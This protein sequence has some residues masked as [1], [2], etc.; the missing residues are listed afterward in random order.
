MLKEI[1]FEEALKLSRTSTLEDI[2]PD[3]TKIIKDVRH[4]GNAALRKYAEQYGDLSH[5]APLII[6]QSVLTAA[7][8]SI[9][10]EEQDLLYRTAERIR[11]FAEAQ[12]ST[13]TDLSFSIPGGTAGHTIR[14]LE[15]AACYVPG[16]RYPLPSSCLMTVCTA[17]TAGVKT[18][19]VASPRPNV[20]TMAA[21]A[22]AGADGL[23]AVG[24]AQAIAAMAY[25]T[26]QVP[27]FDI[28]VGPGNKWV[29]AAK[30]LVAGHVK[31]DMLAGPS[32]L[33]IVADASAD[34]EL[35]AADLL[36][37]AE[38]DPDSRVLLVTLDRRLIEEVHKEL[39]LQL[40]ILP[41]REVASQSISQGY[42]VVV[43]DLTQAGELSNTWGPEHLELQV[44]NSET[45]K[46][47]FTN[48]GSLFLGHNSAEVLGDY[49][50]GPNH[51]LPTSGS[52]KIRGGLS[53]FD[54]LKVQTWLNVKEVD[55]QLANDAIAL[56][57]LEGL[58]AHA[59]SLEKRLA[60]DTE[61]S[62]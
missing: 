25:G 1:S 18:V 11:T 42:V 60:K 34:P 41:T 44:A 5:D 14:P 54:F 49:G 46:K 26:E 56:A 58:S 59:R 36:A 32:E 52:S 10:C 55:D 23:L 27:A 39:S 28:I 8:N 21:T 33:L 29:T 57:N 47:N 30:Q 51:V 50:I 7:L 45:A 22:V 61:L 24:G 3:V 35:I 4:S 13:V 43:Q 38:H 37:Q 20:Y 6:G 53:V 16:G 48:Y 19:W 62:V 12:R 17:K 15:R 9:S 2:L 31:I 40:E